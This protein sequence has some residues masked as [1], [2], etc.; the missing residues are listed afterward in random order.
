MPTDERFVSFVP[1]FDNGLLQGVA[2]FRIWPGSVTQIYVYCC[3]SCSKT[4]SHA[5]H[6]Y[7]IPLNPGI[8]G[9]QVVGD[10]YYC[11]AHKIKHRLII[12]G[13]EKELN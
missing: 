9:W 1:G 8:D 4:V 6:Y 12:D 11:P 13:A 3:A 10:T 2:P 5:N 7:G